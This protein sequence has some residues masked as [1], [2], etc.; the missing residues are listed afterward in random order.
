MRFS[1]R[2]FFVVF[3]F[4]ISLFVLRPVAFA[5]TAMQTPQPQQNQYM[6]PNANP[7]VPKNLHTWTQS[8]MIEVMSAAIC[9]LAGIDPTNPSQKCLGVDPQ[10]QKIGFVQNGGGMLGVMKN[11]IVTL[12][13]PP[14]HT[15]DY[16][17]YLAKNFGIAKSSYAAAGGLG[18]NSLSPLANLWV[19]FRNFVYLI[20]V[21]VFLFIGIGIMLRVKIDPRTVMTIQNQ[22]PKIIIGLVV[23]TFSFAI[24]GFLIDFMYVI[25]YLLVNII[26]SADVA[27]LAKNA[28]LGNQL[29]GATNPFEALNTALTV[30]GSVPILGGIGDLAWLPAQT[31]G[32]WVGG[33]FAN[34]VGA[35]IMSFVTGIIG[36]GVGQAAGSLVGGVASLAGALVGLFASGGNPLGAVGGAAIGQAVGNVLGGILGIGGAVVGAVDAKDVAATFAGL[37]AFLVI[38]IAILTSLFRLWIMLLT[39][40]ISI[41]LDVIFAP[42]WIAAGLIPGSKISFS[43][44]IRDIIAN[45]AAFPTVIALFL[46]A[47]VIIDGFNQ[48]GP[49]QTGGQFVAPLIGNPNFPN[50]IGSLIAL[51][52]V[53]MAPQAV[54]AIKAALKVPSLGLGKAMQ[55]L[56]AGFGAV[57]NSGKQAIGMRT[58]SEEFRIEKF[59]NDLPVY[60]KRGFGRALGDI[61]SRR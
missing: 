7:D 33:F 47:R 57:V 53:L 28:G 22:I 35:L 18:F 14:L 54:S 50:S 19:T 11:M 27:N 55:P 59:E 44:W 16:I 52:I 30:P 8:V 40:Y 36:Y 13:T 29:V 3:F 58:A 9:Q 1:V 56:G 12:Y 24:A 61:V 39:S 23:V 42:I 34:P 5:Q 43:S 25:C 41:L 38:V 6:A 45:L 20:F 26:S 4:L 32:G 37:I 60:K 10:T 49:T 2:L 51:G 15:G 21:I 31:V 17:N 48:S 46:L